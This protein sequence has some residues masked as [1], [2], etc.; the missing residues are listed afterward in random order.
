MTTFDYGP[1][2]LPGKSLHQPYASLVAAGLKPLETRKTRIHYRGDL[3][4]C[5]SLTKDYPAINAAIDRLADDMAGR[6]KLGAYFIDEPIGSALCVVTVVGCRPLVPED[7]PRSWFYA[8]GRW[9]W[10]L[11]NVRRV[12]PF[13]VRGSQGFFPVPRAS[14][15]FL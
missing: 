13:K 12:R 10:E 1:D 4:I 15:E 3:V 6:E 5:S 9:A 7:E 8:P 14:L 11:E 2:F